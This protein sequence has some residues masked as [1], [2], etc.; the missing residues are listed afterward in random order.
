[1]LPELGQISLILSLLMACLLACMPLLGA[2]KNNSALMQT[3]RP[4]VYA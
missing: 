3:A 2:Q 4:L 1:M